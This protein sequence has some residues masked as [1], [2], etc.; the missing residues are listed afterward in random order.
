MRTEGRPRWG[1]LA[2][3]LLAG[4]AC[5]LANGAVALLAAP[6]LAPAALALTLASVP[7]VLAFVQGASA[8]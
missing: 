1:A 3:D 8:R 7:L 5:G 4:A 6:P 2:F